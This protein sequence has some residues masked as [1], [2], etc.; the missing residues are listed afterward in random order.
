MR[1]KENPFIKAGEFL[2]KKLRLTEPKAK[3]RELCMEII[4]LAAGDPKAVEKHY[5]RK[6]GDPLFLFAVL[7][8]IGG[9]MLLAM[10]REDRLV[11]N[12]QL[13]RP[14]YGMGER[15]EE[16]T[17]QVEGAGS[18][19][20]TVK[21]Q[22]RKYT[23]KE[24]ED[25]LAKGKQM[26]EEGIL[27]ENESLDQVK[28]ALNFPASLEDGAVTVSWITFPY[29]ILEEDG[30]IVGE[31]EE[32]GSIVEIQAI[33][34]CQ[35]KELVYET[36][37]RIYPPELSEEEKLK[38]ALEKEIDREN[39]EGASREIFALP[40]KALGKRVTWMWQTGDQPFLAVL[41]MLVIPVCV[42]LQK[43]Q[44]IH[45]KAKARRIQ[46]ALDYSEVMWKMTMLLGAGLTIRGAFMRIGEE[47]RKVRR[48]EMRYVYEEMLC[49]C[50]E[51]K[52]GVPEGTA[53]ENFGRRCGLPKYVKF[54]SLLS[55][56]LKKGSKGLPEIL[57]REA[58]AAMEERKSMARKLGEQAGTR[59]IFPMILMF[60]VVL[61]VLIIPA[62][63]SF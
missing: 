34:S 55:Q 57:A 18:E 1:R 38:D 61:T 29:G 16:L 15:E 45:E 27:G 32:N 30:S 12:Q 20:I 63:L 62:F 8:I 58:R 46:L 44:K 19:N 48:G 42:Y 13:T 39:R 17:A 49:A 54:G 35:G 51:M 23:E 53:Y 10:S 14:E 22:E 25:L 59:L 3:N 47:Y 52:S 26:L 43:D 9:I 28:K 31:P 5:A 60:G 36:A 11:E 21:V 40:A 24:I 50:R 2:V 41:L 7:G 6:I 37:A 33:L 56:S 4:S